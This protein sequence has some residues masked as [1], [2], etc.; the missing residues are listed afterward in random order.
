MPIMRS[1]VAM[2]RGS[3]APEAL[4]S[5][6]DPT[7]GRSQWRRGRWNRAYA[8]VFAANAP[9]R[10]LNA[11]LPGFTAQE[12]RGRELFMTG[13]NN[14]GA[15]CAACHVPPTYA[16]AANSRSNGLDAGETTVF[17]SPSLKNVGLSRFFMHDGRFNSLAQ[18]VEHYNSGNQ[19]GPA[20]DNRLRQGNQPQRLIPGAPFSHPGHRPRSPRS[21]A[22][23]PIGLFEKWCCRRG[24]NSR[25]QP[26]QGCALPLSYGSTSPTGGPAS[27]SGLC[28]GQAP[29][30]NPRLAAVSAKRERQGRQGGTARGEASRESSEAQGTG[31]RNG[32]RA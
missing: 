20:L 10:D 21:A 15:G 24:L 13:Q 30:V 17:K 4:P 8:R 25:P 12:N 16:L 3:S 9:N 23:G 22:C 19:N 6:P 32:G 18:V 26:Y 2:P 5:A 11:T 31:A 29:I 27:G 7:H 28:A 14:G 1:A